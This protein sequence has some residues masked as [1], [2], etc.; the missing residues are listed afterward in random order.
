[1]ATGDCPRKC[2]TSYCLP[3]KAGVSLYARRF[4]SAEIDDPVK[5]PNPI[6]GGLIS[7]DVAPI[8]ISVCEHLH[9]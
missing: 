5:S 2:Q 7:S 4:K 1:M 9:L 3:G 8:L 6:S